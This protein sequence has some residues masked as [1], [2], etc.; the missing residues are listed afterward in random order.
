MA[1]RLTTS[2]VTYSGSHVDYQIDKNDEGFWTVIP[3]SA[4][5]P[6]AELDILT[7]VETLT[8]SDKTYQI[9]TG[10]SGIGAEFEINTHTSGSQQDPSVTSLDDGGFVVTWMSDNQD[11]SG[12]GVYGQRYA[13]DGTASGAEFEINTHTSG[14]QQDPSVTS[15]DDGGFVVTW[16]SDNQDGSGWGVYGQR[17]AADGTASGAEFKINTHTSSN[18]QYP[19]V[20]SLGDGGFVVTWMDNSGQDGS[21]SGIYGQRY[22]ADGTASGAEFKI[23]THTSSNQQ[24][25]SVTSL[26]DGG[27][28]VTWMSY[29]QDGSGWGI[30]GQRYAADGAASGAEF[31]INTHTSNNQQSPSVT[32]LADGGFVVTWMSYDQDGSEWGIYGQRYAA[33]GAASGA[34]FK[35]NTHT[36]S[37][38]QSP[39][40]TSLADGG[41]VVTWMSYDQDGSGWGIYG[42]R[43]A[44]DG[45]A[46]GSEFLINTHTS[47]DQELPSVTSLADGGFVVTWMSYNQDGSGSGIYGQRFDHESS[48]VDGN[49]IIGSSQDDILVGSS[50]DNTLVGGIGDDNI[51]GGAGYNTYV[52]QGGADAYYWV[53]NK[54]GQVILTDTI[55]DPADV[56]DGTDEGVDTLKNIQLIEYR[57]ADGT[58]ESNFQLDDYSNAAA[59]NN[60]KIEYGEWVN[61][62]GN[63][64]GDVD[65]FK[66]DTV[67]GQ[68]VYVSGAL[69]SNSG[70]VRNSVFNETWLYL[71]S[72]SDRVVTANSTAT[73]DIY[74]FPPRSI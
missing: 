15:L 6:D 18:Q 11:G 66:L 61:G 29:D 34:E 47:S 64:Y 41:F 62:R 13:A 55:T 44:A 56:N 3:V 52:V 68:K 1:N 20:A 4:T 17:Y 22:A 49:V 10:Y 16:M 63:F 54:S 46:S 72:N 42:Q 26:G 50:S 36:S 57:L 70:Y 69:G 53:V 7:A 9:V 31:K 40:V 65:Y 30:Y 2:T 73:A 71:N 60:F 38:Q 67:S 21:S 24:Y 32:S 28:V 58:L 51:D 5:D 25:P 19:S 23:N 8:F 37:I 12:W 43:Y 14:S 39:S 27:F 48:L 45:A 74:F 35:I 59:D 33:D